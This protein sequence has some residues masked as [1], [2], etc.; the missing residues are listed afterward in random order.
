MCATDKSTVRRDTAPANG[1]PTPVVTKELKKVTRTEIKERIKQTNEVIVII[2]NKVYNLTKWIKYHPGGDLA[3]VHMNGK[4][5]TD[6]Y[7]AFHPTWVTEKRLPAFCIGELATSQAPPSPPLTPPKHHQ[8]QHAPAIPSCPASNSKPTPSSVIASVSSHPTTT[9]STPATPTSTPLSKSAIAFRELEAKLHAEGYYDTNY[10]FYVLEAVKII[11]LWGCMVGLVLWG[12]QHWVTYTVSALL[13][14]M[15]WHQAA[16]VAH[17]AGHSG[18]THDAKTDM[19]LGICL[20]DLL[21]GV[22]V[23]WWKNNHNV[24]HIVTNDA[25][26]DPD[27]QHVPFLA[28]TTKFLNNIY[29]SYYKRVIEFD[30]LAKIL[31][32]LQHYLFYVIMCFGRFNLYVLS[33]TFVLTKTNTVS[34][35]RLEITCLTLFWVWYTYLLAHLPTWGW[36][37]SYVLISHMA[38]MFLHLQITLS[39]FGM[40]TEV[41]GGYEGEEEFA[42]KALRTTMDIECPVWMDWFHGGLQ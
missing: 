37:A 9:S 38:T 35:R 39:H 3:I 28:I 24:H 13:G 12:P 5:A 8:H 11:A 15:C 6:A 18:I 27:I 40:E 25:E 29:S 41:P 1:V 19:T 17:D 30:A 4:D 10:T 21:G 20:G 26:H 2:G 14:A 7:T 33:W 16:F 32:P 42:A 36:V 34:H 22:S 23:G 31:I